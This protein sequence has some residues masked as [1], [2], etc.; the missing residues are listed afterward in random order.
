MVDKKPNEIETYGFSP[1]LAVDMVEKGIDLR[2]TRKIL[3]KFNQGAYDHIEPVKV[4]DIPEVDGKTVF[5]ISGAINVELDATTAQ[6]NIDR[7]GLAINLTQIGRSTDTRI[8]FNKTEL[9]RLGIMLYPVVSYGVLNG[10]SASSYFDLKKNRGFN[11]K[12]FEICR[13]E[14]AALAA[15]ARDKAKGLAP[16]YINRDGSIGPSFI[17]LKMRAILIQILNYRINVGNARCLEPMFQMTSVYNND[18]IRE[19][20]HE[21]KG[22]PYLHDLIAETGVDITAFKTGIQ[23][24]LAALTHSREGR[25]KSVFIKAYG[26]ENT[27]LPMP[28]G[29]GQ[30]FEILSDVYQ[31]LYQAGIRFVYLGNV[32]NLGY[33]VNPTALALIALYHKQAGFDF[34]FRTAVDIKGGILIYDQY[35]RL[36]CADIGPAISPAEVFEAEKSGKS[37]LFNCAT[38]LFN[39]E[40]LIDSLDSIIENLPV[41]ITDQDKDA[42]LYSQAEQVTWEIIGMLDNF[43]IFGVDKYDRF[44]AAKL[45]LE[46]L[47]ASGVG[48][49]HPD[50]PTDP[51]HPK[52]DLRGIALKLNQGLEQKLATVYGMKKTDDRWEPLSVAELREELRR[53]TII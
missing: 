10:G 30:N 24:M 2:L 9:T 47:M 49:N 35:N 8:A 3:D 40:Y 29:H 37:I 48:L 13:A 38:G 17:E 31:E 7:L 25:P 41:R 36:N 22:S 16:A 6:R 12:L 23:P 33:T 1:A 44:L 53:E 39:L 46:G 26:R 52:N 45:V 20:Y 51:D 19:A 14:F 18:L 5:D 43:M 42:G 34:S 27:T 28:G 21:L 4:S 32:D 15:V 11:E 50:Y